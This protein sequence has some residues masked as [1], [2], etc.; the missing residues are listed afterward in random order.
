[1][2]PGRGAKIGFATAN[3]DA[4][5]TILP[6]HGVYAGRALVADRFWPAAINVGSNPTFGEQTP[7]VEAHLIGWHDPLYGCGD[8]TR[9]SRASARC[10]AVCRHCRASRS[11]GSRRGRQPSKS[12]PSIARRLGTPL[13]RTVARHSGT[14]VR[15]NR[16]RRYDQSH[17]SPLGSRS[18]PRF[19]P[20]GDLW[21]ERSRCAH[22][23][24]HRQLTAR[25]GSIV[26]PQTRHRLMSSAAQ[27][28]V[29][30][31]SPQEPSPS[32]VQTVRV[33]HLINGEHYSGA[34]RVQDLLA[35][36][37]PEFGF[38]A[39]FACLKPGRFVACRRSQETPLWDVGMRSRFDLRAARRIARL[40]RQ[41]NY[42]LIHSHTPRAALVGRIAAGLAGVPL[43]HHLHSP[44][45]ADSTRRLRNRLNA[46]L[47]HWS[48]AHAAGVIA[49]SHSLAEYARQQGIAPGRLHVV[50]NGVPVAGRLSARTAPTDVWTL[51]V[52]ALF[53]PRKGLE[54]LLDAL[55]L[56]RTEGLPLRLRAIGGFETSA[57]ED[58]IRSKA[59]RLGLSDVIEWTGFTR[60]VAAQLGKLDLLVLP[61][62]FGEGLPMVVLEAM[63]AGVPVV[64][65]R[66]EGVPEAIRDGVDG[67][68]VAPD[69]PRR[70]PTRSAAACVATPIGLPC[71]S[72][73]IGG[74]PLCFPTER[75]PRE[76]PTSIA[77]YWHYDHPRAT[78]RF[79][80]RCGDD[81]PGGRAAAGLGG[82]GGGDLPVCRDAE[83]RPYGAVSTKCRVA[84]GL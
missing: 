34:E 37:L 9:L 23:A 60:D 36:G 12:W 1:M 25:F 81:G 51:G 45:A 77:R 57:Y 5:D 44:T 10:R 33:L 16:Y 73:P 63:A 78:G 38:E 56:A 24:L 62:L 55:S 32:P 47:E 65:T 54:V 3:V 84:R 6:A 74:K 7:K 50:P 79:I 72:R 49:V 20:R 13:R 22:A 75:W 46:A 82:R 52:V 19:R 11:T 58:E 15:S 76:S 27:P 64:A 14:G 66:V 21:F 70:W 69:D 41:E 28:L 71:V 83:R 29:P 61:S 43:I 35:L 80:D 2:V 31:A 40:V 4:I 17:R 30:A 42:Q 39:A 48:L 26:N 18:L 8:R 68:I 67:L 59:A 53:R